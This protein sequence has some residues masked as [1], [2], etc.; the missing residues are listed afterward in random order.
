MTEFFCHVLKVA[1]LWRPKRKKV[2]RSLVA[3]R[4]LVWVDY[5]W[6]MNTQELFTMGLGI[7]EPWFIET[8][9]FRGEK[10][11]KELHIFLSHHQGVRFTVE[12][13]ELPVYDHR[14]RVWHHLNFFQHRCFLH[15]K[16]PRVKLG[17][18]KV[19]QVEVPWAQPGSMFSLLFDYDVLNLFSENMSFSGVARRLKI[20]DKRVS[21]IISRHV[22]Q[23]LAS[24][25]IE[26]VEEL[27]VDETSYRKGHNYFTILCD[28][29]RKKVVGIGVGKDQKAFLAALGDLEVRGG[30]RSKVKS[31]T[32]DMSDAYIAGVSET[33]EKADIVFDRFH[34]V[35]NLNEAIDKIR[36]T[37]TKEHVEL[38]KTRYLW[39]KNNSNLTKEQK[40]KVECLSASFPNIGKAYRLKELLRVVL[41]EAQRSHD[42][43]PLIEWKKQAWSSNLEPMQ[44]FVNMLN[45]HWYGIKTYFQRQITNDST[46]RMNL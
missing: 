18:G 3:L 22:S 12:E 24:Q 36:R 10:K 42:L 7:E 41:D 35:K 8:I 4:G 38:K 27:S 46:E 28:R 32:M 13:E 45:N 14:D 33:M 43:K 37:E 5:F 23:A 29:V 16:V 21:N 40:E 44:K 9:E 15:A 34:I 1:I 11:M 6:V 2:L 19:K 31:V 20:S 17:N 30:C 25:Q 39:L 26:P